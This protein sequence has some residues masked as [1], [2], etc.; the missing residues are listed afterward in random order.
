MPVRHGT[1]SN[2]HSLQ[3]IHFVPGHDLPSGNEFCI[4]GT[5]YHVDAYHPETQTVYEYLGNHVHGYPPHHPKFTEKSTFLTGRTN[6]ELYTQT[7]E[8]LVLIA[9]QGFRVHYL[10][11]HDYVSIQHKPFAN[12]LDYV[13]LVVP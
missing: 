4:P 6:R 10:W 1:A 9:T 13:H 12:V 5:R 8:R 7:M 3:H 11:D 2:G